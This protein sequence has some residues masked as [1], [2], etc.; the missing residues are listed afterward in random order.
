M[1][2]QRRNLLAYIANHDKAAYVHLKFLHDGYDYSSAVFTCAQNKGNAIIGFNFSTDG[3]DTHIGLDR[4]NGSIQASDLRVRFEIGGY[5]K[6]VDAD[7]I[8][9]GE[10]HI[11]GAFAKIADLTISAKTIYA[12]FEDLKMQWE[13]SREDNKVYLDYVIYSGEKKVFNF[14]E[15]MYAALMFSFSILNNCCICEAEVKETEKAVTVSLNDKEKLMEI[16]ILL[17]PGKAEQLLLK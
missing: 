3:G 16:S 4:I 8:K 7:I 2:N 14:E 1:W 5:L 17:K 11:T 6:D 10:G 9:N 12:R 13:I 15:V